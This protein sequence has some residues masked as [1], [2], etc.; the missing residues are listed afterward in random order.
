MKRSFAKSFKTENFSGV[1]LESS[2]LDEQPDS[3]P[4]FA[5]LVK[6]KAPKVSKK[7]EKT[8]KKKKSETKKEVKKEIKKEVKEPKTEKDDRKKEETKNEKLAV[9]LELRTV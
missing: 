4:V 5:G 6:L 7:E 9:D 3:P 2:Y 8:E 1:K